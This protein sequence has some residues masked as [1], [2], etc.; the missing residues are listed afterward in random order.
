LIEFVVQMG[1]I[2]LVF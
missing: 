2:F 1:F